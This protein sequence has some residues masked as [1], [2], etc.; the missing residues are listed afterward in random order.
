[1][2]TACFS[3]LLNSSSM[4]DL[5]SVGNEVDVWDVLGGVGL[6]EVPSW[7]DAS[8]GNGEGSNVLVA[9]AVTLR[10]DG[11]EF[12]VGEGFFDGEEFWL[13]ALLQVL[14]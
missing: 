1:M 10:F 14:G 12:F 7:D 6:G 8:L 3:S 11:E 9:V 4:G 2:E 13:Y 5:G